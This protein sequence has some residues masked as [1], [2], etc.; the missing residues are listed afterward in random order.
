[1]ENTWKH[2]WHMVTLAKCCPQIHQIS[3]FLA[4]PPTSSVQIAASRF[5]CAISLPRVHSF[6]L[7]C[8]SKSAFSCPFPDNVSVCHP[9]FTWAQP[10][11]PPTLPLV[12]LPGSHMFHCIPYWVLEALESRGLSWLLPLSHGKIPLGCPYQEELCFY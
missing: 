7:T 1:M 5:F 10:H 6:V 4:V 2:G 12:T 9:P 11:E 8:P 3:S